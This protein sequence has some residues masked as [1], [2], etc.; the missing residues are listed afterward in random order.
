MSDTANK[1][2]SFTGH[3]T[4]PLYA[5]KKIEDLLER[6]IAYAYREG[7]RVF[8]NGGAIGFDI[9][10]AE[11]VLAFRKT[12]PDIK[13][14]MLLPCKEQDLKWSEGQKARYRKVL[15]AAD[16]LRFISEEYTPYCMRKR[17]EALVSSADILIAY[18]SHPNSGAAQTVAMAK[19]KGIAV[20][21]LY[22]QN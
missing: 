3:R 21:N 1:G 17:N 18:L 6:A 19:R 2:C 9:L 14:V 10:A 20:F 22:G 7:C 11:R 13:L 15:K 12:N 5:L 8:Y 16:E 4:L